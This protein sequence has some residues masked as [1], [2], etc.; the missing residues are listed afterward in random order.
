[1]SHLSL[2][3]VSDCSSR[4]SRRRRFRAERREYD[5]ASQPIAPRPTLSPRARRHSHGAQDVPRGH[6]NLPESARKPRLVL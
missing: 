2:S 5:T 1:M 6:R 3:L 4:D